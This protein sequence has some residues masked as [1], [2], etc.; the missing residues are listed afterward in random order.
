MTDPAPRPRKRSRLVALTTLTA[1]GAATLSA[2]GGAADPEE[3]RLSEAQYGPGVDAFP[4]QS[5]EQCRSDNKVPDQECDRAAAAALAQNDEGAPRFESQNLC[6][7]QFGSGE[8]VQR[9]AGG[10]S[11][12]TP[13][14][15][16]FVIGQML[17]G[18]RS[19]YRYSGL[20]RDRRR[21]IYYTGG[22]A[23]GGWLYRDPRTGTTRVGSRALQPPVATPR[24]QTRSSVV[25]RGGFGGRASM[26]ASAS[27][28][29]GGWGRGS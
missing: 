24:V 10:G 9:T 11:F 7:E 13:L 2:C 18:G 8:C 21:D 3:A 23:G 20:Y 4:Y 14:L 17:D 25:S 12:F 1:L 26:N 5:V 27:R 19:R 28:S 15:T 16:G 22:G 6:E 29:G